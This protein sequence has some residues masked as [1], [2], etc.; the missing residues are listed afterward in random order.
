MTNWASC[1]PWPFLKCHDNK[2]IATEISQV[3]HKMINDYTSVT[4]STFYFIT[5]KIVYSFYLMLFP[6]LLNESICLATV[7]CKTLIQSM[8][9]IAEIYIGSNN[10]TYNVT[11]L[12][13]I[14]K[15]LKYLASQLYDAWVPYQCFI[16][17][18]VS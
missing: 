13:L 18:R 14:A 10:T 8:C 11:F 3:D 7:R 1:L 2:N 16:I 17:S 9:P 4:N 15:L 6:W 5:V 12:W